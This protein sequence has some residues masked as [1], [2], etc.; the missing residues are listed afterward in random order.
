[1]GNVA[2]KDLVIEIYILLYTM[3][4]ARQVMRAQ[5]GTSPPSSAALKS[6]MS[7]FIIELP[8]ES[9]WPSTLV[10]SV[11]TDSLVRLSIAYADHDLAMHETLDVEGEKDPVIMPSCPSYGFG[12]RR[13]QCLLLQWR[14]SYA[15]MSSARRC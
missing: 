14:T 5:G 11:P 13:S 3:P 10:V 12:F 15:L 4:W 6:E 2:K 8:D 1:M 9:T 7:S